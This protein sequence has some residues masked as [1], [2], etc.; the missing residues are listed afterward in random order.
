MKAPQ[1]AFS[2]LKKISLPPLKYDYGDLA[3]VFSAR[4]V[5]LHHKI[6]HQAYVDKYN[7]A[8]DAFMLHSGK[9]NNEMAHK[10]LTI[11]EFGYGG[12]SNHIL[13]FDALTPV[14]SAGPP[15][16]GPL[17]TAINQSFGDL[18]TFIK[19]FSQ[20]ASEIKGSGWCWLAR[21]PFTS[22]LSIAITHNQ[23][24]L[25]PLNL[26]PMLGIDM[27]EHTFYPN[28]EADKATFLKEIW[29]IVDWKVVEE[30][31]NSPSVY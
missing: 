23:C 8:V 26:D 18:N 6:H 9:G 29:K 25:G 20:A 10:A 14:R 4:A 11:K 7:M 19:M 28:Y 17:L 16:K 22:A 12:Y 30:R 24:T 3:P 2:A 27:W 5:E 21:N 15:N 13:F 31:F 1:R